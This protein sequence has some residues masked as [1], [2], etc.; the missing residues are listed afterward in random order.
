[1]TISRGDRVRITDPGNE[2][3]ATTGRVI[4]LDIGAADTLEVY[5]YWPGHYCDWYAVSELVAA[6]DTQEDPA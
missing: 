4:A 2:A 1:M 5:V 3:E 6:G